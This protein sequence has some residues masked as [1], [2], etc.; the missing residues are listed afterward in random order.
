[1][2][3]HEVPLAGGLAHPGEVVRVGDTVRRPAGPHTAS[4]VALH[5]HMLGAGFDGVPQPL[6]LDERGRETWA[7]IHGDVPIPPFPAWS[8]TEHALAS[9]AWLLRRYHD[10]AADFDPSPYAWSDEMADPHGGPL[11]VH[12]DVCPENVVF[13]DG[14]AVALLDFDFAAP[15]RAVWDVVATA[16]MWAPRRDPAGRIP[17]MEHLDP[18]ARTQ[19]FVDAY[20]L[21]TEGRAAF[22]DTCRER[23]ATG[24]LQRRVAA[25]EPQFIAMWE[26]Q[27]GAEDDVRRHAWLDANHDELRDALGL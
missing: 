23:L 12:T 21:D 13:R 16:G 14:E 24:F 25:G 20:G 11:V 7:F 22:L 9:V 2:T 15:G 18:I 10:A 6:G 1:V 26:A 17:G 5:E 4:I 3:T 27:G 19:V 8:M